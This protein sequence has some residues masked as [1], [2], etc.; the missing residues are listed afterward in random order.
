MG[1]CRIFIINHRFK[2]N[3]RLPIIISL[4]LLTVLSHT[5]GRDSVIYIYAFQFQHKNVCCGYSLEA[6]WQRICE[7]FT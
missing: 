1:K 3:E 5:D 2:V 7:N 4:L 6:P